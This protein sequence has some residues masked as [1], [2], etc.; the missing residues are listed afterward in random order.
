M[1]AIRTY[2]LFVLC[3]DISTSFAQQ[4][5]YSPTIPIEQHRIVIDHAQGGSVGDLLED[6]AYIPLEIKDKKDII[7]GIFKIASIDT[8]LGILSFR[9]GKAFL[10]IYSA[11]GAF[12]RTV[13][14]KAASKI[15]ESEGI[16]DMKTWNDDFVLLSENYKIHINTG[17]DKIRLYENN[18]LKG[19]SVQI[20]GSVW[21]FMEYDSASVRNDAL[22]LNHTPVIQYVPSGDRSF[23]Q[24]NTRFSP[25][26]KPLD[27]R[28]FSM[29]YHFKIFELNDR[30]I[31]KIYDFIFPM[32]DVI[33]TAAVSGDFDEYIGKNMDRLYK[34]DNIVWHRDYL[35]FSNGL[36][37]SYAF[38]VKSKDFI[39][40][41]NIVPDVSNDYM[42]IVTHHPIHTDGEY[43]YTLT[44]PYQIRRAEQKCKEE[45]HQMRE[46]YRRLKNHPN[47]ILVKFKLKE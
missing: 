14:C 16:F 7:Q 27:V 25:I 26:Y 43:L 20:S 30:E 5:L 41:A 45:N 3:I 13:D 40:F 15:P 36:W 42:E 38:N 32:K 17:G 31:T 10:S 6:V 2:P 28:Y 9:N 8:Y 23:I 22:T 19:D 21:R 37:S 47:P 39:S 29:D 35:V 46:E 33:D 11:N 1:K 44:S 4:T 24:R 34:L 18:S 12:V